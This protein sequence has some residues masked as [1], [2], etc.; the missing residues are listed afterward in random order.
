M[1]GP[2]ESLSHIW[3]VF[4]TSRQLHVPGKISWS[5]GQFLH[6]VVVHSHSFCSFIVHMTFCLGD[7]VKSFYEMAVRRTHDSK[8]MERTYHWVSRFISC[9]EVRY[10][11]CKPINLILFQVVS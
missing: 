10:R 6:I 8:D 11:F 9:L 3:P 5:R 7:S 2:E 4:G 1:F